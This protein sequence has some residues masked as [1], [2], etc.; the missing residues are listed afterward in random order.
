MVNNIN[1]NISAYIVSVYIL[2]SPQL[3]PLLLQGEDDIFHTDIETDAPEKV[4]TSGL[5]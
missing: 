5:H 1:K 3:V 4:K 2:Q